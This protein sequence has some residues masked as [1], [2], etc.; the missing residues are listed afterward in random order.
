[1]D[2]TFIYSILADGYGL[3]E[4]KEIFV[5][6]V[7]LLQVFLIKSSNSNVYFKVRSE[8]NKMEISWALGA[9][10]HLIHT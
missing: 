4:E 7:Q 5:S 2:L 9:A 3:P 10:F 8:V 6:S 1:M